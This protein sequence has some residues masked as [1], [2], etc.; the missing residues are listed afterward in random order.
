MSNEKRGPGRPLT[1]GNTPGS[2]G[3]PVLRI[4]LTPSDLERVQQAGGSSWAR[5]VILEA[6]E[7]K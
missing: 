6:L 2:D 3:N 7:K 4:R 5:E 1:P